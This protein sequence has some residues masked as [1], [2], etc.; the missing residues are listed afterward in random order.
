MAAAASVH[1]FGVGPVFGTSSKADAGA[2]I[3]LDTLRR[4]VHSVELPVVAIGGIT[5]ANA[6]SVLKTGAAGIAV[7]SAILRAPDPRL[8]AEQLATAL[9]QVAI[10]PVGATH[11][12]RPRR[13][14]VRLQ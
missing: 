7:V 10:P 2:A 6:P 4:R 3:G 8:A 14:T 11:G 12:G 13:S 5:A 9:G 1:Y